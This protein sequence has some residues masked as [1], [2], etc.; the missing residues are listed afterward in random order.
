MKKNK[1]FNFFKQLA[2]ISSI[3]KMQLNQDIILAEF[4]AYQKII[5]K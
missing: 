5:K 4:V 3:H 2:G 1:I